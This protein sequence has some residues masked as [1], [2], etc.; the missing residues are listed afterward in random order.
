V[1]PIE[2]VVDA[3]GT[4]VEVSPGALDAGPPSPNVHDAASKERVS[5]RVTG[6]RTRP[7]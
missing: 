1:V 5:R 6:R 4:V 7:S 2:V 3:F